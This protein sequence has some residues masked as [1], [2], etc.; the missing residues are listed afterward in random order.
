VRPANRSENQAPGGIGVTIVAG[1]LGS[2]KTTLLRRIVRDPVLGPQVAV[3]VNELGALGLDEALIASASTTGAL[4]MRQL[5]TGCICCTLRGELSAA[6]IELAA[7]PEAARPRHVIIETSGAALASEVSYGVNAIGFEIPFHTEAVI[8]LV[9]AHNAARAHAEHPDLFADQ[10]RSADLVLL[11]KGDLL[12]DPAAREALLGWLK[13]LAP[14]ASWLWTEHAA[15]S[16][17]LIIGAGIGAGIDPALDG[18]DAAGQGPG[19]HEGHRHDLRAVTVPVPFVVDRDALEDALDALSQT[20]FRIKGVVDARD[21]GA[22]GPLLVQVVGDRIDLDE[23]PA[24]SKL[25]G[26]ARRLI[27]IGVAPDRAAIE[28]AL[29]DIRA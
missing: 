28:A 21:E 2:G 7:R 8:T 10:V 12:P 11:N 25:A 1:F 15:I 26:E 3:I 19:A 22:E 24:D 6:L 9:D 18:Q 20:I 23:I 14:R 13:P 4:E 5:V 17:G 27:F 29:D 16:P